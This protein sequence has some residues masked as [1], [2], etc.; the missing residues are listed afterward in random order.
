MS[1][2]TFIGIMALVVAAAIVAT[3][4]EGFGFSASDAQ[5]RVSFFE[6][7]REAAP[8]IEATESDGTRRIGASRELSPGETPEW[9]N[10]VENPLYSVFNLLREFDP[11]VHEGVL[12]RSNLYKVLYDVSNLI[13]ESP[14]AFETPQQVSSPFDF[15]NAPR[16]YS[17]GED[18]E[19]TGESTYESVSDY[20]VEFD[21][22]TTICLATYVWREGDKYERGAFE[23]TKNA[24]TGDIDIRFIH[25]LTYADGNTGSNL[26]YI[27]G[28]E[29][30]HT[31][32]LRY[33]DAGRS[34]QGET[35]A[36]VA[37]VGHGVSQSESG[38][39]YFLLKV[40]G[41]PLTEPRYYKFPAGATETKLKEYAWGG[42]AAAD[43]DDPKDYLDTV[44]GLNMLTLEDTIV[45]ADGF[46]G[47][48]NDLY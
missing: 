18:Q 20:A 6:A 22:E 33:L 15:G 21:G 11:D 25:V 23:A 42:Y 9:R 41:E 32:T 17:Y 14:N 40:L 24:A 36:K 8:E 39:D 47:G 19:L 43:I 48:T 31:F 16:T 46:E 5:L 34:A 4:C 38:D 2:H 30:E 29:N 7:A 3:G 35:G 13:P 1:R 28:N 27:T 44:D 26:M 12:D 37:I 45:S 10:D